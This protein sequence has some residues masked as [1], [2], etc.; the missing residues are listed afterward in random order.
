MRTFIGLLFTWLPNRVR[1]AQSGA[2]SL[3]PTKVDF[4]SYLTKCRLKIIVK[5]DLQEEESILLTYIAILVICLFKIR[6]AIIA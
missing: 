3:V 1:P 6:I 5:G 4:N 2:C